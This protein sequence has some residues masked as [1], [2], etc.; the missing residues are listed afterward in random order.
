MGVADAFTMNLHAFAKT[1]SVV[2]G[3]DEIYMQI[4]IDGN[5]PSGEVYV[6]QFSSDSHKSMEEIIGVL[7]F[8]KSVTIYLREDDDTFEGEDDHF[9]FH[10]EALGPHVP[11]H[12]KG[13]MENASDGGRY[14]I[15]YN[16][17][18]GFDKK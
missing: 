1:D 12:V 2:G 8:F 14:K 13:E 5:A 10:I 3:D 17:A 9:M 11:G 4:S 6:G 15:F 16:V 7:R 18:H